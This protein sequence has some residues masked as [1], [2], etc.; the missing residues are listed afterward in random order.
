VKFVR[1]KFDKHSLSLLP[2]SGS[3]IAMLLPGRERDG[4][5]EEHTRSCLGGTAG[6]EVPK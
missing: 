6:G 3:P 2:S 4:M 5:I 1:E